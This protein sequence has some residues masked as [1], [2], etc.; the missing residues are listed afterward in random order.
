LRIEVLPESG[1]T[2]LNVYFESAQ[3]ATILNP[4]QAQGTIEFVG[5]TGLSVD[6]VELFFNPLETDTIDIN[7]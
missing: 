1:Q 2:R 5:G 4:F 7:P 6:E 3:V